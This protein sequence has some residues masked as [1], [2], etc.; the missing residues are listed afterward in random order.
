M[1]LDGSEGFTANGIVLSHQALA[2]LSTRPLAPFTLHSTLPVRHAIMDAL[3][4]WRIL[5]GTYLE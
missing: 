2:L 4:I 3:L 5:R 1:R